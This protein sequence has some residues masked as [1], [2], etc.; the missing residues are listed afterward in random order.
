MRAES[1]ASGESLTAASVPLTAAPVP[2]AAEFPAAV[3]QLLN[4]RWSEGKYMVDEMCR[5]ALAVPGKMFRPTLLLL[6]AVAVGGKAEHVLSAAV[7]TEIG[8]VASLV[9][10]DIIDDDDLRRGQPTVHA[11]FGSDNA[12]VAGDALIFDLFRSLAECYRAGAEAARVVAALEIVSTAGIELC[13]GQSLE[14]ELTQTSSNDVG[15]YLEMIRLKTGA[16]FS[17]A[18]Q[19]GAALGG[20]ADEEIAALG[21]YGDE[22]GI[23]FQICDDLLGYVS[24]GQATGK[25]ADSDIRN[26]R[27]TLPI[28]L[29]CSNSAPEVRTTIMQMLDPEREAAYALAEIRLLLEESGALER[30]GAIARKHAKMAKDS[31]STL[32]PSLYR[33]YL[34]DYADRAIDRLR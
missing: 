15:Q 12:I 19:A 31:L 13:R 27:M 23:A 9:H 8:H 21:R 7:G 24:S 20:G 14:F 10:D 18:C 6:S 33:D 25:S 30:S 1:L 28:I 5:H 26:K 11:K 2:A 16:L 17:G 34:A 32:V 4:C 3:W 22:L 29:A